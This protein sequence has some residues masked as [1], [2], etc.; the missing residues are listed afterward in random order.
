MCS[1]K[2]NQAMNG[3]TRR[4]TNLLASFGALAVAALGSQA[5]AS[6]QFTVGA[7]AVGG[8][9]NETFQ[10]NAYS[11]GNGWVIGSGYERATGTNSSLLA[12]DFDVLNTIANQSTSLNVGESWTFQFGTIQ[13]NENNAI[14]DGETDDVGLTGYLRLTSPDMD[15]YM[16]LA[17]PAVFTGGVP[18]PAVD[19]T[20]TFALQTFSFAGTGTFELRLGA[21]SNPA[22]AATQT[23][24]SFTAN[25]T[26]NVYAT[27]TLTAEP[28]TTQPNAVVPEP[29]MLVTWSVLACCFGGGLMPKRQR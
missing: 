12:V 3:T 20:Y 1:F 24:V 6:I 14:M 16:N 28:N 26:Q 21:S 27:I 29:A 19:L 17:A 23:P 5:Y 8:N 15:N 22:S 25:S 7:N 2:W 9:Y 10:T 4:S 11:S 13:L 18:D